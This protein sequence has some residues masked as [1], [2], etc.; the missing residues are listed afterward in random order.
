M[1]FCSIFHYMYIRYRDIKSLYFSGEII[2]HIIHRPRLKHNTNLENLS[3][4]L[5]WFELICKL[6]MFNCAIPNSIYVHTYN[7]NYIFPIIFL[8]CF[9]YLSDSLDS[10]NKI[11]LDF[12]R[13]KGIMSLQFFFVCCLLLQSLKIVDYIKGSKLQGVH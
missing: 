2:H 7:I 13:V 1:P 4:K 12:V 6:C 8:Y 9:S 11:S 10:S 3:L 5:S